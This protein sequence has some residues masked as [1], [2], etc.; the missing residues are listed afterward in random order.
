MGSPVGGTFS[1]V[2]VT[3]NLFDPS[4]G[5]QTVTY[6]YTNGDGCTN[7]ATSVIVVNPLPTV[8]AGTYGPVCIDAADIPLEG[9]PIS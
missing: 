1:G 6:T 7:S 8:S 5:T 2:G 9:S 3:G 4:V